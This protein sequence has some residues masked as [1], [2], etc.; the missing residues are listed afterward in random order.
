MDTVLAGL[1]WQTCHVYLDDVVV[2]SS[3]FEERLTGLKGVLEA[4]RSEQLT[5]KPEKFHLGFQELKFLGHTVSA[6]GVRPDPE[7]TAALSSFP[8]PTD[9]KSVRRFLG[10]RAYCRR[11]VEGFTEIPEQLTRITKS[12]V[13]SS[14]LRSSKQCSMNSVAAC[15]QPQCCRTSTKLVTRKSGQTPVTLVFGLS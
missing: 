6:Q 7:K 13:P 12:G 10:L 11:F 1:K 4:I 14:G 2:F 9:K 8:T 15:K 5:I 3:S